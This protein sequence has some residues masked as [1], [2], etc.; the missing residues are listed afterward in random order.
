MTFAGWVAL[1]AGWYVTE[2]GRQPW[3]IY[4]LMRVEDTVAAHSEA[5]MLGTVTGYALLYAFLLVS[6]LGVL[7]YLSTKPAHSLALRDASRASSMDSGK[8]EQP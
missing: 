5:V 4:G 1:L 6:Y 2:V 8:L 3:L 7:R